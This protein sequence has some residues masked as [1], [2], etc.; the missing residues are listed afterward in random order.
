MYSPAIGLLMSELITEGYARSVDISA[1][2]LSRFA[3]GALIRGANEY[4]WIESAQ[5]SL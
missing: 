1:F 3:E 2:R 5:L 4:G